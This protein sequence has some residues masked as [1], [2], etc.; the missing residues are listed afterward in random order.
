VPRY[1]F[2]TYDGDLFLPDDQGIEL[3]DLAA[4]K[5]EASRGLAD[6]AG[7]E[8]PDGDQRSFVV[9]VRDEAGEV[10]LQAAL[11]SSWSTARN[12]KID[13]GVLEIKHPATS[14]NETMARN[15]L[16][17]RLRPARLISELASSPFQC[18]CPTVPLQF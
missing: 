5:A 18:C 17:S 15:T 6:M 11:S 3:E 16:R 14:F 1:F 12:R 7:D 13:G 4:V 2:D 8:L 9:R 10:V